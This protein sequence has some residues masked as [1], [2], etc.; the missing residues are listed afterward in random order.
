MSDPGRCVA[1]ID[2]GTS[3]SAVCLINDGHAFVVPLEHGHETIPTA[4]FYNAEEGV[5]VFGRQALSQ[6]ED[7][8]AGRIM[9]SLK[10]LL[11]SELLR[12]TTLVNG[13]SI[14]YRHILREFL[15]HLRDV[16]ESHASCRLD[17]LVLGRPVHFVDDDPERDQQAETTLEEVAKEIGFEK[18]HFQYEPIAAALDLEASLDRDEL[19]LVVDIGGGTSDFSL[20]RL[21]PARAG[22][23]DRS[24]DVLGNSGIHVAGTDFDQRLS[25]S[26]VMRHLGYGAEGKE[27]RPVPG[28]I[29]FELATW[30]K[31]NFLYSF[32][33][34]SRAEELKYFLADEHLHNRLMAVLRGRHGHRIAAHVES[35]KIAVAEGGEGSIDL[36]FIEKGLSVPVSEDA[37]LTAIAPLLECIVRSALDTVAGAGMTAEQVTILYFTG[38][39]TGIRQLRERLQQ[40][41]P[42]S[43]IVAGDKFASVVR[44]LGISALTRFAA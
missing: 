26:T 8:T 42:G 25:L 2:F 31:I 10:S 24:R 23:P 37:L 39:S 15:T 38:G 13:R 20:V 40:A 6:Y 9:R 21:G 1:A 30:H 32:K 35:A 28:T 11:G 41:F 33:E 5:T 12:E 19:A 3:N 34:Q 44:G 18:V 36:R 29:Y 43:R 22:N 16:A 4:V 14:S 27:G 17:E 7:G